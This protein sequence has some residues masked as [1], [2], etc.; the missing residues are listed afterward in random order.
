MVY[1]GG[2]T[3]CP[4]S[5]QQEWPAILGGYGGGLTF[6]GLEIALSLPVVVWWHIQ[7]P[8]WTKTKQN[9]TKP[10]KTKTKQDK[11]NIAQVPPGFWTQQQT[12]DRQAKLVPGQDLNN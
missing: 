3:P 6:S 12:T 5:T 7:N 2:V 9:Q 8:N 1:M 10:N 4:L 11:V